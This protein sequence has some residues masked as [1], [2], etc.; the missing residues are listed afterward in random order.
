MHDIVRHLCSRYQCYVSK[1]A[2]HCTVDWKM[3]RKLHQQSALPLE[4]E[5]FVRSGKCHISCR[6]QTIHIAGKLFC[7]QAGG[8]IISAEATKAIGVTQPRGVKQSGI[9]DSVKK[10][11]A[12]LKHLQHACMDDLSAVPSMGSQVILEK[13]S[14]QTC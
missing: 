2:V 3:K 7:N 9:C 4:L 8:V 5:S 10:S 6:Q 13:H 12:L 1:L 14:I 11:S